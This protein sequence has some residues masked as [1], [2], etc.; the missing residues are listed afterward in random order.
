MAVPEAVGKRLVPLLLLALFLFPAGTL[1]AERVLML[2]DS[3]TA[4]GDWSRLL[5]DQE[6]LNF[7]V[8][9]ESSEEVGRR[10]PRAVQFRP[11][12]IFLLAGIND[13]FQSGDEEIV[14]NHLRI[15]AEAAEKMPE[16]RLLV[17]S[18]LP[19]SERK[20]P[21]SLNRRV[22]ALNERLRSEAEKRGLTYIDL[23]SRL[24][25]NSGGLP[26]ELTYDGLHLNARGYQ[27]WAETI[28]PYLPNL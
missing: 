17:Q 15:W 4:G 5:P 12:L 13:F 1:R 16:A 14:E 21:P 11:D 8:S 24:A 19:V 20:Y 25:D 22:R 26:E 3:L 7:G 2:G 23:Y 10:L 6:T 9:G 27:L 18:L 28:R